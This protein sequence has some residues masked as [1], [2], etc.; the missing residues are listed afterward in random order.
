MKNSNENVFRVIYGLNSVSV[1][2]D[3]FA[4]TIPLPRTQC[5][6]K[7]KQKNHQKEDTLPLLELSSFFGETPEASSPSS[8]NWSN[9]NNNNAG[10][11]GF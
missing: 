8:E 3:V 9:N 1:K 5:N 2:F 11:L 10:H 6:M 7:T 4:H